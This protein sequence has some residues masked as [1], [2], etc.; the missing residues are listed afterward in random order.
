MNVLP[1]SYLYNPYFYSHGSEKHR[2][3]YT[4]GEWLC[5]YF[6]LIER[7]GILCLSFLFYCLLVCTFLVRFYIL[8]K[9]TYCLMALSSKQPIYPAFNFFHLFSINGSLD[10]MEF[11]I[12]TMGRR[13]ARCFVMFLHFTFRASGGRLSGAISLFVF[14]LVY[15]FPFRGSYPPGNITLCSLVFSVN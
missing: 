13:K 7:Q 12:H 8:H 9:R 6:S 3:Q 15:S 10:H 5:K 11:Y 2:I 4:M 1:A 14:L